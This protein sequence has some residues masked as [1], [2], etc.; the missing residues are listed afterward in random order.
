MLVERR[1]IKREGGNSRQFIIAQPQRRQGFTLVEDADVAGKAA[2]A[3]RRPHAAELKLAVNAFR[4]VGGS[5]SP[6]WHYQD[7][8]SSQNR[9]HAGESRLKALSYLANKMPRKGLLSGHPAAR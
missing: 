7:G 6:S 1:D 8:R 3:E 4:G 5:D 9:E 2:I